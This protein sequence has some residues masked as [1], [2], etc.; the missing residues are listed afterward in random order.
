M[1]VHPG[2]ET[3][4][5][6]CAHLFFMIA[7]ESR[8]PRMFPSLT[9]THNTKGPYSEFRMNLNTNNP[10]L[11]A[12]ITG[13]GGLGGGT[14]AGET[15]PS[16]GRTTTPGGLLLRARNAAPGTGN[17]DDANGDNVFGGAFAP[18]GAFGR[19]GGG[20]LHPYI[21]PLPPAGTEKD[22][23]WGFILGFFVGF[24]MLFWVWMPTVPHKQKI[25]IISGICFQLALNLLRKSGQAE[26]V[27]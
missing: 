8:W 26:V 3:F 22:F 18:N 1:D 4:D 14:G 27:M 6:I 24:I 15:N 7:T 20:Y 17:D 9:Y 2:E 13:G 5:G 25:G 21:G 23:V 12:A 16:F 11:L 10:L 19:G